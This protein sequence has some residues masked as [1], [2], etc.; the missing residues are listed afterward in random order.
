MEFESPWSYVMYGWTC[1][2]VFHVAVHFMIVACNGMR[3]FDFWHSE[4][5]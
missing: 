3:L 5:V 4:S 1:G 2:F